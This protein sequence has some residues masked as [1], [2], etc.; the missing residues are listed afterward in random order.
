MEGRPVP[1]WLRKAAMVW[2]VMA[3]AKLPILK[4]FGWPKTATQL[5]FLVCIRRPKLLNPE[6]YCGFSVSG[7]WVGAGGSRLTPWQDL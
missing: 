4:F 1:G 6:R 5:R 3:L 7:L 2:V